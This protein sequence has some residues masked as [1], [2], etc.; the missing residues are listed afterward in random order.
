M[1]KYVNKAEY[2]TITVI[3]SKAFI[4]RN[5]FE[6]LGIIPKSPITILADNTGII[7]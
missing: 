7:S 5:L 3:I 1:L 2:I 4:I 6:K